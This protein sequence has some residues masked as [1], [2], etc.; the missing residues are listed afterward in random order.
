MLNENFNG[1]GERFNSVEVPNVTGMTAE[2]AVAALEAAGFAGSV[3]TGDPAVEGQVPGTVYAQSAA[4]G[5]KALV[6]ITVTVT[7]FD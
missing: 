6:G 3:V 2:E 4:A 1:N 7:V 5:S